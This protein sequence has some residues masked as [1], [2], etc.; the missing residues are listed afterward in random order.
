MQGIDISN[1]Q[2]GINV[3]ILP[4]DFVIC[5]ATEGSSYISPD[6]EHQ[7]STA[8]NSGKCVG[9]Y[10]YINGAGVEAEATH[11]VDTIKPWLGKAVVCLDWESSSNAAWGNIDYL[12]QLIVKVQEK[13]KTA[14]L[15]YASQSVFPWQVI[16][17][18][19][20]SAWVAQYA[21][22]DQTGLQDT[23]WNEGAY[24]CAIRQYSSNGRIAGYA[25]ALDLN[26]A[27]IDA[28][29]WRVLAAID[30]AP[31]DEGVPSMPVGNDD[32]LSELS[33]LDLVIYTYEG[34]FGVGEAR[35]QAL[36]SRYDEVMSVLNHIAYSDANTLAD[37]VWAGKYGNGDYRKA[38]LNGRYDEIMAIV[39]NGGSGAIYTVQAGDTLSGI[40]AKYGTTVNDIVSKNGISNPNLIY[41]GQRLTV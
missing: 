8:Y 4:V 40:A 12:T 14:V 25:G 35:K 30:G 32:E 22:M 1:W 29:Q 18:A 36:G 39:N 11:F 21:T 3:T 31:I 5:K 17:D 6:F 33:T 16:S 20:N 37:E 34:K 10:H 38:V 19:S 27:Y 24:N 15:V 2:N 13:T 41:P 9:A 28:A 23:P 26:K 7:I